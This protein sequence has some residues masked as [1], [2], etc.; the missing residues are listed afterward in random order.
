[1]TLA[2]SAK[3][4]SVIVLFVPLLGSSDDDIVWV[5]PGTEN[6]RSPN[7]E[8]KIRLVTGERQYDAQRMHRCSGPIRW[9]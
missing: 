6:S 8:K 4:L 1:M 7:D 2:S 5:A 3:L 9:Q